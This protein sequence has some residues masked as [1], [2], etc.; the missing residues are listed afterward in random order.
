METAIIPEGG[1]MMGST[2]TDAQK[3][4]TEKYLSEKTESIQ[5]RVPKGVKDIWKEK[6]DSSGLSLNKLIIAL[7]DEYEPTKKS[8]P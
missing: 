7:M 3:R 5:I 6:A 2:Y 8:R 4:A 1:E